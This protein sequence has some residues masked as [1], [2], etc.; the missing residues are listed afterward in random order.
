MQR[1]ELFKESELFFKTWLRSPKSMG[2]IIPSSQSLAKK[3]AEQ[4][5]WQPGQKIV[6]LGGGTGAITQ[7]LV[8]SGIPREALV[9][10]EL[11]EKL[12]KYLSTRFMGATV[13]RGDATKLAQILNQHGVRRVS[14]IIS[15]LP[16]VGMPEV[17]REAIYKGGLKIVGSKGVLLQYSY[18]PISPISHRRYGLNAKLAGFV[19]NNMPPAFVWKY[20]GAADRGV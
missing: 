10:V 7:G 1:I 11:D 12:H 18:S 8:D 5:V 16:M 15:G 19:L 3:V 4:V 13:V 9:V 6:E 20:T 17:F 14:T 2:S